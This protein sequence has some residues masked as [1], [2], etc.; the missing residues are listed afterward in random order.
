MFFRSLSVLLFAAALFVFPP[1]A[2]AQT[3]VP[4]GSHIAGEL[5]V[6]AASSVSDA[7]LEAAY[8][9]HGGQKIRA[10]SQ[11]KVHHIKVPENA[12]DAVEAALRRN[13]KISFAEKNFIAQAN[14]VPND[15]NF[16]NQWHLPKVSAPAAWDLTTGS[17]SVVV[18]VIDSGVDPY[19]PDLSNKLVAGYNWLGGSTS[20][21][22][23]V[24]GHGTAVAGVIGADTN[25]GI[26][27]AG[28]AW[29][30]TIMPL[31]VINSSNYATYANIAA[32][33]N[34]AAD[35]GAKVINMSLGGTSYSSTLQNAV[36]YAWSKGSVIVAAA[37]NNSSSAA[38]YPAALNN[39][40]AV[41]A[42]DGND[43]LANFSNFGSWITVAAPGTYIHTT[44]NGGG[45]GNWQGT[46]FATPQVA[47]LA[48]LLFAR[49]PSLS[50][51]QAMDLIKNNSDDLGAAGFDT[52]F[53]WGRINAYR[54]VQAVQ[55][56]PNLSVNITSPANNSTVSSIVT[57]STSVSS[58]NPVSRVELYVNGSLLATDTT[59]PFAFSWD[60]TGLSG[61]QS[62]LAKVIDVAGYSA[63]SSPITVNVGQA[64]LT[65][66][67]VQVT[68]VVSS[69]KSITITA[70]ASDQQGPVV[71]VEFY[72]DGKLKATDTAAPWSA[73][74]SSKPLGSGTHSVQAR[75]YDAAGNVAS[76]ATVS[77]T[78]R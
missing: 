52:S 42:T 33:I 69:G 67:E 37:G 62:L 41:S 22:H 59:S 24:L 10:L 23:D 4:H 39:V 29:N 43:N 49:N 45:Y 63:T 50:N 15:P 47:A 68:S 11:I 64:D 18:A 20:D 35:H 1:G 3:T 14:L 78:T 54:A 12:L 26:G 65:P 40:I 48:A 19:H 77:V 21:T 25:S 70:S 9:G 13:P 32:A 17:S 51:Q 66:P 36:N 34:Y 6:G 27:V 72:V 5:L 55:S 7:D 28:L 46:S 71:K 8:K 56:T 75:A 31:V 38:F 74:I 73:K 16:G 61:S 44:T 58:Q 60:T 57:V 76:S 53:G 30:T 2:P